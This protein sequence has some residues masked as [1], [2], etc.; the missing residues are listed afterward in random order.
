M[1]NVS[2]V[3]QI[4]P[5]MLAV[6]RSPDRSHRVEI[7]PGAVERWPRK[8]VHRRIDD[9]ERRPVAAP[10]Y[11]DHAGQQHAGVARDHPARLEHQPHVPALGHAGDHRAVF[12]RARQHLAGLV[13]HA[14]PAAE[15]DMGDRV[16]GR[17]QRLRPARRRRRMRAR[18]GR[19]RQAGCRC[20][21]PARACPGRA[22]AASRHRSPRP[23]RS[24]R[25]T[26]FPPCRS[27]SCRACRHRHRD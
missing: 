26:C 9:H 19:G 18:A 3:S 23:G 20:A 24:A 21:P 8:I 6:I 7:V 16:P 10:L 25:R 22:G 2:P 17:A 27:R 12:G 15:I 14:E 13:G 11:P 1:A 5:T 4:G